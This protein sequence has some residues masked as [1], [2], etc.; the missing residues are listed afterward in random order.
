MNIFMTILAYIFDIFILIF[1]LN[2]ILEKRK[3]NI[4]PYIF[5]GAFLV[6]E[7]VLF[8]NEMITSHMSPK[9]SLLLTSC[10]SLVTTFL[11]TF[12][13]EAS[14]R[15]RIFT[16]LSFQILAGFG[17]Y[18][19]TFIIQAIR[20]ETFEL[21]QDL[22]VSFMNFG[23]KIFL[24][25]LCL[26]CVI[27]WKAIF[28]KKT[29]NYNILLFSTPFVSVMIMIFIPLDEVIPYYGVNFP[30]LLFASL[31]LLNIT[32]YVFLNISFNRAETRHN[33]KQLK[34]QI[35]YQNEK[36]LQLSTAYKTNRSV[37]HDVKKHYF[38]IREFIKKNEYQKLDEYLNLAIN[39]METIY[40][41]IN[42]GNLVIDSFVSNYKR[43]SEHQ[44][45]KFIDSISVDPNKIPVNDYDLC[46][47]L[48]NILDNSMNACM[49]NHKFHNEIN[50]EI[51]VNS[52]DTF[53]IYIANTFHPE[54]NEN[55]L[56]SSLEHGYGLKNVKQIV[57]KYHGMLKYNI[58]DSADDLFE[59]TI[60]IPIIDAKQR[61]HPVKQST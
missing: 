47:I 10:V 5:Y 55:S 18:I 11:L 22:L 44:S 46:I 19:F 48:G 17:E 24:Y 53:L 12:L 31:A 4:R 57:E 26:I 28:S 23:S 61:L 49:S 15:H 56:S 39:D 3:Y 9:A 38:T 59:L 7:I 14:L 25:L 27:I 52:N 20:P 35:K 54:N 40:A 60:I 1:F 30:I 34:Q 58:S 8:L 29:Y 32:N 36:Y 2:G 21:Q 45:I 37:I 50:L 41:D 33:M 43:I 6:M 42:T 13:Y 16:T 51:S